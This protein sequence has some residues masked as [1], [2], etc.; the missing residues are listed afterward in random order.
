MLAAAPAAQQ[1][2]LSTPARASG[3]FHGAWSS[4]EDW[5]RVQILRIN[6]RAFRL[7]MSPPSA[8][9]LAMLLYY[10]QEYSGAFVS[11]LGSVFAAEVGAHVRR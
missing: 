2:L 1:I 9:A 4:G 5:K 10:R 7:R 6:A 3:E 11:E 8:F